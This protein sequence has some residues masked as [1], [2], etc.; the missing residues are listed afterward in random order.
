[1]DLPFKRTNIKPA[2]TWVIELVNSSAR[3]AGRTMHT[4][5][6]KAVQS[7]RCSSLVEDGNMLLQ[8]SVANDGD[9]NENSLDTRD[10]QACE[11]TIAAAMMKL[12]KNTGLDENVSFSGK[13]SSH[14]PLG[15]LYSFIC[16]GPRRCIH[17]HRHNGSNNLTL[18]KRGW[19]VLYRCFGGVDCSE[20]PLVELEN[21][22]LTES[23]L[24]AN[25]TKLHPTF[26]RSVFP[27]NCKLLSG[28][29]C[30][31]YVDLIKRNVMQRYRGMAAIFSA[32]YAI[33]GRILAE[34]KNFR[35]WNARR[36]LSDGS[37]HVQSVFSS[38]MS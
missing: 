20:R 37:F 5:T 17:G 6:R 21:L 36:W 9:L 3:R 26:D 32:I 29:E 1:M 16:K 15:S 33:D 10:A 23:L 12:L 7:I 13:V 25:S 4:S 30:Q 28:Q 14:G 31:Y 38:R 2:P 27:D 8:P 24:D 11:H 35:Y 22:S 19:V 34:G 18:A